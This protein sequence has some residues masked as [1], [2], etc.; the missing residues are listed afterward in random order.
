MGNDAPRPHQLLVVRTGD[1]PAAWTAAGFTV[2]DRG[3]GTGSVRIGRTDVELTG[4]GDGFEGWA[5]DGVDGP[6]DGLGTV[7]P[8]AGDDRD[9][10]PAHP[11]GVAR[12]D[13]LVLLTG[14]T[15]RT[16]AGLEAVGLQVRGTRE[17]RAGG[18]PAVQVFFWAGDVILELVGPAE[19]GGTDDGPATVMGLA[20]AVDDLDA[21]ASFLGPLLGSPRD[22]VQRSRQVATLRHK[23]VG[24]QLPLLLMSP[25]VP[26]G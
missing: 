11:N 5:L 20:L 12:I 22:A 26:A 6:V 14:D 23:D 17:T 19:G 4:S 10:A 15:V 21:T 25:H 18:A 7:T 24:M 8:W 2:T 13:H 9:D 16:V 1:D 3:D